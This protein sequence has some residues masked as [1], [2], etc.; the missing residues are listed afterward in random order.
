MLVIVAFLIQSVLA[1]Q[2]LIANARV[3][4]IIAQQYAME[5]AVLRSRI[6]FVRCRGLP[7]AKHEYRVRPQRMPNGTGNGR[8]EPGTDGAI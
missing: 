6:G 3:H 7:E 2:E 4:D 1:G 8:V 5:Q